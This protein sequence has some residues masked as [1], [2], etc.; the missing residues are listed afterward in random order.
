MKFS[1]EERKKQPRNPSAIQ[2]GSD[3]EEYMEGRRDYAE[4]V[5]IYS[6]YETDR[7]L[8]KNIERFT[9]KE[10]EE[11]YLDFKSP[12]LMRLVVKWC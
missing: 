10:I 5:K 1:E 2:L 7:K 12:A 8:S 6:K 4:K 9:A 11:G 3:K